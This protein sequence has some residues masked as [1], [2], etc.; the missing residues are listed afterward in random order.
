MGIAFPILMR[1]LRDLKRISILMRLL[2]DLKR[3]SVLMLSLRGGR[4]NRYRVPRA[5]LCSPWAILVRSLRDLT[6]L[7][8]N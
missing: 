3:I 6:R 5:A 7:R 4:W 1:S 8:S 2:W